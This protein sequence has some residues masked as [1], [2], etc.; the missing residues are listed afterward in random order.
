MQKALCKGIVEVQKINDEVIALVLVF[1][2][3][4]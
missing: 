1:E 3:E 2:E 4:R